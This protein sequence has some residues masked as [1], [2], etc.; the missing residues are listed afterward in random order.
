MEGAA[1]FFRH[2]E[3][4]AHFIFVSAKEQGCLF[5]DEIVFEGPHEGLIEA[6]PAERAARLD[7]LLK[8]AVFPFSVEQC[9]AG[10]Q[11]A[12]HDL[13]DEETTAFDLIDQPLADDIAQSIGQALSDLFLKKPRMRLM[14]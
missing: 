3:V 10:A 13:G 5:G 12:A 2:L 1:K 6:V 14:L 9:L 8:A 4:T 7:D 11:A